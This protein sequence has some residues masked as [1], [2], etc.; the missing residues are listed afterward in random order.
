MFGTL[1]SLPGSNSL[2]AAKRTNV[3]ALCPYASDRVRLRDIFRKHCVRLFE[4]VSWRDGEGLAR[5]RPEIVICEAILPDGD[6]KL[7]LQGTST[8]KDSPRVIVIS[9]NAN[10]SLWVEVLNLGGYDLLSK[11]L[12]EEEVVRVVGPV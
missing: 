11:P 10:A 12:V 7:V 8:L 3:L 6:W 2:A 1:A 4:A 9:S 5:Y